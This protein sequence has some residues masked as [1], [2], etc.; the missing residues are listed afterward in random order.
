MTWWTS[1]HP[2]R[3]GDVL[4][5]DLGRVVTPCAVVL[6]Q[7]GFAM[8]YPRE[9]DVDVSLDTSHWTP[10]FSGKLGGMMVRAALANEADPQLEIAIPPTRARYL[11]L[12]LA[13]S[14]ERDPWVVTDV[15]VRGAP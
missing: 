3:V 7:T 5:I 8:L 9:L 2:Q 4:G 6:Y 11:K 10:L 15:V 1:D 13:R 14:L 12:T